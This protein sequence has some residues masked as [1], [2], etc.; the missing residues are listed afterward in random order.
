[1][2]YNRH[3]QGVGAVTSQ[4]SAT[5][6]RTV[7]LRVASSLVEHPEFTD[8]TDDYGRMLALA[9]VLGALGLIDVEHWRRIV[10]RAYNEWGITDLGGYV[11]PAPERS[12]V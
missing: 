7:A 4:R 12:R 5:E 6:L 11:A 1:M 10:A 8:D 9:D 2:D 3:K